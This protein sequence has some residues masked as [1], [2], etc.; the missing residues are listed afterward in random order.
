MFARFTGEARRVVVLAQEIAR[1]RHAGRIGP[2]HLLLGVLR[3]PGT[4]GEELLAAAGID[5]R[6]VIEELDRAD[7]VPDRDADAL[8]T[9]GIDLDAVRSAVEAGFGPGALDRPRR[10]RW[11]AGHIPFE[12]SSKK[13]LELALREAIRLGDRSIGTEHVLL[14]LLHPDTAASQVLDR[15][16]MTLYGT[17]RAVERRRPRRA[18]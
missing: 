5:A 8:A 9:L 12:R 13:A 18:G 2:E 15:H 6:A 16:G 1:T 14:G 4:P 3:S 7:G 17:R 10:G 11:R